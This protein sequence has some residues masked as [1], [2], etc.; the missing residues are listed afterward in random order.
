[1]FP[2]IIIYK[3]TLNSDF[4]LI[5]NGNLLNSFQEQLKKDGV[6]KI[7]MENN[8]ILKYKNDFFSIKPGL[9]WNIWVG[10]CCG[11]IEVKQG[12]N[13][14]EVI[15]SFNTSRFFIVGLIAGIIF[16][17]FFKMIFPGL[18]AFFVLGVLNWILSI[19]RHRAKLSSLLNNTLKKISKA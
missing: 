10:I 7:S 9:N 4:D 15:Y 19:S 1:M 13:T 17:L 16:S 8:S 12:S 3:K 5:N 18:F 11:Q 14:R 6:D 2:F